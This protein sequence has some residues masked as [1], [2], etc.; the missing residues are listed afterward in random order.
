MPAVPVPSKTVCAWRFANRKKITW[1][2]YFETNE[3]NENN[4]G[5]E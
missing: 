4:S 3:N 2:D 5:H 1:Y